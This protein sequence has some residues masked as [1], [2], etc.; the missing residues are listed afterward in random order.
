MSYILDVVNNYDSPKRDGITVYKLKAR[1]ENSKT[2]D[3]IEVGYLV[4]DVICFNKPKKSL[5]EVKKVNT[6]KHNFEVYS[7]EDNEP[8]CCIYHDNREVF[9]REGLITWS[10]GYWQNEELILWSQY[11]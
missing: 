1:S 9:V 8:C 4:K 6:Y 11:E 2:H 10:I 3:R 7:I 5:A